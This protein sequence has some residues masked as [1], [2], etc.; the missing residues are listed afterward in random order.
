MARSGLGITALPWLA[1][2]RM[3]PDGLQVRR[4]V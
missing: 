4:I 1:L 2:A 3:R